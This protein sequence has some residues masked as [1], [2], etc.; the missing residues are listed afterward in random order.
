MKVKIALVLRE[1]SMGGIEN[2]I[3]KIAESLSQ[4]HTVTIIATNGNGGWDG[5]AAEVGADIKVFNFWENNTILEYIHL[6]ADFVNSNNFDCIY[7]NDSPL[8]ISVS[9]MIDER[10]KQVVILHA[11]DEYS[12]RNALISNAYID[13]YIAISPKVEKILRSNGIDNVTLIPNGIK[14]LPIDTHHLDISDVITFIYCGRISHFDKGVLYIPDLLS[15]FSEYNILLKVVGDGPDLLKLK[16]EI[17]CKG[18]NRYVEYLGVLDELDVRR[19]MAEADF[20]LFPSLAEGFGLSIVEAQSV[21]CIPVAFKI[22]G[23]TDFIIQD[24][25]NG[26]LCEYK[27]IDE[28]HQKIQALLC[29]QEKLVQMKRKAIENSER[30]S[31]TNTATQWFNYALTVH[32]KDRNVDDTISLRVVIENLSVSASDDVTRYRNQVMNYHLKEHQNVQIESIKDKKV[33]LFGTILNAYLTYSYLKHN[34]VLVVGFIDN[35]KKIDFING[36]SI[37]TE[38]NLLDMEYD[39]IIVTVESN[40]R[41]LIKERIQDNNQGI[42]VMLWDDFLLHN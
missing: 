10:I 21:G 38:D 33:I 34:G 11:I 16:E 6:L 2:L 42:E 9:P 40:A 39:I 36:I 15:N 28:M 37:V 23:V 35:N 14:K 32:K 25:M 27:N 7:Y 8:G 19:E 18:L 26:I 20:L 1:L 4:E 17:K 12:T 30:F 3:L 22:E 41:Y 13:G 31:I 24:D 5:K 29:N